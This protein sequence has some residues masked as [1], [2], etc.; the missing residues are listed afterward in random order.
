MNEHGEIRVRRGR[1]RRATPARR[2]ALYLEE[3]LA[4]VVRVR[5]AARGF[6]SVSAYI[7]H[8]LVRDNPAPRRAAP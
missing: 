5:A 7:V 3:H 6:R 1:P 2:M 4:E 8:L